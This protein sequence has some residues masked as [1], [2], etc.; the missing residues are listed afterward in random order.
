V[1]A[2]DELAFREAI[3][4][5]A[6]G[7]TVIT[8]LSE[9]KPAG[10]TASAVASLSLSP[11]L[12]LV[13][14][15]NRLPTHEAIEESRRFVV[16]VLGEGQ[17]QLALQFA[18]PATD[19][20]AG[21]ALQEDHEL[22]VLEAAI[23]HFVCDVHERFPGGD[24]SIFTGLVQECDVTPGKRPLLYFRSRFGGLH[25]PEEEAF[26]QALGWDVPSLF[27]VVPHPDATD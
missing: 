1:P 27:T 12:L 14:I 26:R 5:F 8:T 13:C 15:D 25:D 19:K 2:V 20:F 23:A 16:N 4:H 24:H 22:P 6:T 21:V 9:G 10:M 11:V 7:V 3:A 17:E 18:R